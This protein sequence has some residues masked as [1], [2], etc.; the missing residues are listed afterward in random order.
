V[1]VLKIFSKIVNNFWVVIKIVVTLAE[2]VALID[3]GCE[4]CCY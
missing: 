2:F 4:L 1:Q 3:V